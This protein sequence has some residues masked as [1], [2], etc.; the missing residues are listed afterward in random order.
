M[1]FI[2]VDPG[3]SGALSI[4]REDGEVEVYPFDREVYRNVL[5]DYAK[6]GNTYTAKCCV[7]HVGAAPGNGVV[8]MFAFGENFGFIQGLLTAFEIPYELVRPAK[9]KKEFSVTKDKNTSIEVCHRL[10]PN[11]N[12]KRTERCKKDDDGY[13]ESLL[14]A[15]YARRHM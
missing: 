11:A 3:K 2:G 6:V 7:E 12:L 5:S 10:F 8:G 15:E 1:K 4:I 9:W 14:L 13:A